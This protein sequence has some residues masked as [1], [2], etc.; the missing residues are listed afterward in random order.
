MLVNLDPEAPEKPLRFVHFTPA[1]A[2]ETWFF[3]KQHKAEPI[4][5]TRL[6]AP[7][8]LR[9]PPE[10]MTLLMVPAK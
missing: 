9:L 8:S 1:G 2:A 4:A 7:A 3:D 5:P 6:G 10:S